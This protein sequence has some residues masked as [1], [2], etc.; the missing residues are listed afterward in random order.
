MNEGA[1]TGIIMPLLQSLDES[2]GIEAFGL[3]LH[4]AA[5]V[6]V[7]P[8]VCVVGRE[9]GEPPSFRQQLVEKIPAFAAVR[10]D[11]AAVIIDLDRMRNLDR[12]PIFDRELRPRWV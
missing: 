7:R 12:V 6:I 4:P 9:G 5:E 1:L 11:G 10:I 3:H 2:V 8:E